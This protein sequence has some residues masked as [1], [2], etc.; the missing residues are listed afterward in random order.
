MKQV[1][2]SFIM[3]ADVIEYTEDLTDEQL[4]QLY[5]AQLQYANGVEPVVTDPE[6]QGIWRVVKLWMTNGKFASDKAERN[7]AKYRRFKADVLARDGY[8]CQMCGQR[9]CEL[10]VHHIK[11]FSRFPAL[12]TTVSNGITL[13]KE[14]HRL[15]HKNERQ[16]GNV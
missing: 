8:T 5:R 13:C 7:S 11:R 4:G 14:C 3:Y 15:V 16:C 12:R 10:H 2:N 1:K 6:V 9:N